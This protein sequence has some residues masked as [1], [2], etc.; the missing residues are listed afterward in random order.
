MAQPAHN[1]VTEAEYLA[2]DEADPFK[3]E[4]VNGEVL[5][6]AGAT[7][8]HSILRG[9]VEFALRSRLHT[10]TPCRVH[11]AD[12][13]VRIDETGMYAYPDVLV[14]CEQP[15]WS[16]TRPETL[17]NPRIVVEILSE[18]TAAYDCGPKLRHY[19]LRSSVQSV[20][21]VDSRVCR[22]EV[23]NRLGETDWHV[24]AFKAGE[25]PVSG[26]EQ[27]LTVEEIYEGWAPP[28]PPVEPAEP[29]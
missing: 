24:E 6:M 1:T 27:R 23:W 19:L 5:A 14:V 3:L 18:S 28:L 12:L 17:L 11:S 16:P 9:N 22:I 2:L 13:R 4:F 10:R 8:A 21:L 7:E 29:A 25:F 15:R 20:L 26:V